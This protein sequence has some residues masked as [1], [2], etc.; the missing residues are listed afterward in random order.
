MSWESTVTYYQEINE[1]IK[2]E[3]GGLHSAECLLYSVDFQEIERCQ[4]AGEWDQAGEILAGAARAL[5]RAG[6]EGIVI[7]TNTMHKVCGRIEADIRVPLLHIADATAEELA[8]AHI[9][10]TGLLGTRY[11]MEQDFYW[12]RLEKQGFQVMIP[13]E[14]ERELVNRV[15]FEEL[16]QG[17]LL[18]DSK[19]AFLD[20]IERLTARG[21]EGIILGCT[22]IG[23]LVHQEDTAA[24]LFDT[25]KIHA[26]KAVR[27]ALGQE[28][29][30]GR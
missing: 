30:N 7:C 3:L 17:I 20:I 2:R 21:A 27:F 13:E 19:R 11:T 23:L 25:T 18:E 1:G 10:K 24:K 16:C 26:E 4:A 9:R 14:E 8:R 5:E 12:E 29:S 15:I 6:A 22:E 28:E